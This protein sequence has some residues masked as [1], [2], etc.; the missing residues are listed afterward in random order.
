[1]SQCSKRSLHHSTS[2]MT[3]R[4]TSQMSLLLDKSEPMI[5]SAGI[6]MTMMI[7]IFSFAFLHIISI[8]LIN[9]NAK[10]ASWIVWLLRW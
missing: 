8:F 9:R 6:K 1:M 7:R 4:T 10:S 3:S 5:V 2:R